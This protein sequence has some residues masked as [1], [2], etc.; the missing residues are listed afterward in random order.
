[1]KPEEYLAGH[2]VALAVFER[3]REAL[4]AIEPVEIRASKSQVAFARRRAFAWLWLPSQYLRRS[5]PD[6]I[7]SLA[8]GRQDAS[9]RWKQVNQVSSKHWMHHLEVYAVEDVDEE[10]VV[11]LREAAERAS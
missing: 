7:L 10:V 8:L 2:S 9:T 3:V 5:S 11:W 1:M 4:E 6:V